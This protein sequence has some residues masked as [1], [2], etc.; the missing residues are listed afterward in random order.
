MIMNN[1]WV[2]V[3]EFR[4]QGERI[5]VRRKVHFVAHCV[6]WRASGDQS[7][8]QAR[9]L[10]KVR[11]APELLEDAGQL[12]VKACP[13]GAQHSGGAPGQRD[14]PGIE[15]GNHGFA[16]DGAGLVRRGHRYAEFREQLPEKL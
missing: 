13:S 9:L 16:T 3:C 14:D 7:K 15:I 2:D 4:I 1:H 8:A 11:A 12:A 6:E 10:A 5:K